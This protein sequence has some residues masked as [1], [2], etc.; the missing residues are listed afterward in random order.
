MPNELYIY[1]TPADST[2]TLQLD[3]GALLTGVPGTYNGRS[4]G[5]L[6]QI[7]AGTTPQGSTLT[8]AREGYQAFDN[9][10][11][12]QPDETGE[13]FFNCNDVHLIEV[14][15][16]PE[17]PPVTG[18]TPLEI[19]NSVYATGQFD[20]STKAGCGGFTE[21]CCRQLASRFGPQWGH[22]AK[23]PGQNQWQ[24]H[25]VDALY[26][27]YGNDVGVWDIITSSVS[28]SAKPAFND[29][30]PGEPEEWRPASPLPVQPMTTRSTRDVRLTI[31]IS[32]HDLA[33]LVA[34]LQH[35]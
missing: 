31:S 34:A 15:T 26:S 21:E 33:R 25:A 9:R 11:Y 18:D 12:L 22:I 13:A 29:A 2:V 24:N 17:P 30:G 19:I 6:I 5:H 3:L 32:E 35:T 1:T 7:P 10:G 28:T 27:L 4:D 8:V 14:A 23:S 16:P 20:L